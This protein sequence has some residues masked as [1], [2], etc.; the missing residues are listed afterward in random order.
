MSIVVFTITREQ[1]HIL[2]W[3]WFVFAIIFSSYLFEVMVEL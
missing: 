1:R 2:N 3:Q